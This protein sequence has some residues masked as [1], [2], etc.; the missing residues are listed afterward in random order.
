MHESWTTQGFGKKKKTKKALFW[1]VLISSYFFLDLTMWCNVAYFVIL[2]GSCYLA[3]SSVQSLSGV[4]LF[5]TPWTAAR[6]ASLSITNSQSL[7]KPKSIESVMPSSHL[8]LSR[9]L[10]FLPS[11]FPSIF[12][13][14]VGSLNQVAKVLEL[15]HQIFQWIFRIEI[16]M[17]FSFC[18]YFPLSVLFSPFNLV[19]YFV[20]CLVEGCGNREQRVISKAKALW[21]WKSLKLKSWTE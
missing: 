3:F 16:L 13:K 20:S 19:G 6:Q 10:L 17:N 7:L 4:Q 11:I 18:H 14:W 12:S 21:Q 5:V 8:I 15:Q 1:H 2:S 9:P